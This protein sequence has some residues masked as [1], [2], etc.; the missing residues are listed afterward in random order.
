MLHPTRP[1]ALRSLLA[2]AAALALTACQ[3][4][5]RSPALNQGA[6]ASGSIQDAADTV[7]NARRQVNRTTAALR[8]LVDRPQDIPAQYRTVLAELQRL[9]SD[10]AE[11]DKAADYMRAKGDRY[12]AD[13]ARQISAIGDPDLRNAAFERRSEVAA[14]LQ[15]IFK[16]HQT[17][18]AAYAPYL[19]GLA[20]IQAVLG[21]DLGSKGLATVKPFV[22][23]ATADA[24]PLVAALDKLAAEFRSVGLSLQPGGR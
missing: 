3:S 7:Q 24:F 8:N 16:S 22:D 21:A 5:P 2:L 12:L 19:A 15:D 18:K 4:Q 11:I 17:V 23:K 13:W 6:T 9:K 20:D 10:A 1:L 14:S